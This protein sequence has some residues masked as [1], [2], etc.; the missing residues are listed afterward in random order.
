VCPHGRAGERDAFAATH[1]ELLARYDAVESDLCFGRL[2][3]DDGSRLHVGRIGLFADDEHTPLLTDWRAPAARPFYTATAVSPEGVRLRRTIRTHARRVV[4]VDDEVLAGNGTSAAPA[5]S[6]GSDQ[7]LVGEAA[8]M[9]A[10]TARRTGRMTDIVRTIQAEQDA[11]IRSPL[12]ESSSSRA[13]RAPARRRSPCTGPP[14]C[15]SPIAG[16]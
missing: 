4:E 15:C 11:A 1:R 2:D 3:A 9:A 12:E 6:A 10:L 14:T 7:P 5:K 13:A 8:L 16:G